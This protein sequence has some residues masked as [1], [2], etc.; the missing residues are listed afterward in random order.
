MANLAPV[1]AAQQVSQAPNAAAVSAPDRSYVPAS[2]DKPLITIPGLCD[3]A[4]KGNS[5]CETV[6]TQ[7]QFD[8][9]VNAIQPGMSKHARREFALLYAG[10]LVMA[11]KAEQLGLDKGTN[12]EVRMEYARVEILTQALKKN[13]ETESSNI[14]DSD[15]TDYYQRNLARFTRAQIER[16]Y[17]PKD[18]TV[19]SEKHAEESQSGMRKVA[20][21]L[22]ARAVAGE[23]FAALQA[24]A[25]QAAGLKSTAPETTLSVRR[26]SLPPSHAAV[27]DLKPGEVSAVLPDSNGYFIYKLKSKEVL[28]V[29]QV[30]E[31]IKEALRTH[32]MEDAMSN[33]L[34]SATPTLDE[35]YFAR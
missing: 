3:H 26:I 12:Y 15:V 4:A 22:R 20:D 25:Y 33:I 14:P 13:I 28:S 7:G 11:Q 9:L 16:I 30:R 32:R 34:D 29:D 5:G 31:E 1:L 8:I 2:S 35:S 21:D 17:I 19:G 6:I 10:A 18:R 23:S 24:E 27:M